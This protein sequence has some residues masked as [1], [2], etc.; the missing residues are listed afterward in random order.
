MAFIMFFPFLPERSNRGQTILFTKIIAIKN[1]KKY[2]S[3]KPKDFYAKRKNVS[4]KYDTQR[5]GKGK[6]F[7]CDKPGHFSK[8]CKQ[9]LGKLK[10]KFNMLNIDDKEQEELF[11]ILE[12]KNLSDSLEDDFSSSSDSCYQFA[13]DSS[14]SPNIKLSCRD[15]CCNVI[16]SVNTLTKGEENEKLIVRLINQIQN[17]ELQKEYLDKFKKNLI[18][19]ETSKK[20]KSTISFEET[21]ERFNKKKSKNLT[22]ND[23]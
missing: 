19:N 16:K 18:K 6:C 17:L 4:K 21:L 1:I 9:K 23:L 22:V 8:D 12:S 2:N 5:S 14:Y 10:N 3:V 13:D 11:R 20:I 7:N 15:S